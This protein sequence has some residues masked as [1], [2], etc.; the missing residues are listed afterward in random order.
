MAPWCRP[1]SSR[2]SRAAAAA[3]SRS[4]AIR[5]T[6]RRCRRPVQRV[7]Q[8][9]RQADAI[10]I[11]DG[12]DS[13]SAVVQALT[14]GRRQPA[15]HPADRHRPVGRLRASS[16]S[17]ALQG[18]WFA[19]PEPAGFRDFS[20]RYRTR[21]GQDPVRTATLA[22]DA[23][24]LVAALVKTQGRAALHR[25]DAD[26]P[27]GLRRHRRRLPLPPRR[28]QPARARGDARDASG[29]QVISPAPKAFAGSAA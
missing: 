27:V 18:G 6:A 17:R 25:A 5:S 7:A 9:A 10:F 20:G 23:V 11:P 8:A 24:S 1:R 2:R 12:A 14:R 13:V 28:H 3:S 29:G 4:S 22:Y 19:A 21:Y 15:A 16:P 26:Q